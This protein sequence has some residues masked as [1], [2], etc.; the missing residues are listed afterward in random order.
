MGRGG[1][2]VGAGRKP[3]GI[4]RKVSLTLTEDEWAKIENSGGT[5]ATFLR[6][7]MLH[8]QGEE[9]MAAF[10]KEEA[11]RNRKDALEKSNEVARLKYELD[12]SNLNQNAERL[13]RRDVEELWQIHMGKGDQYTPA[14]LEEAYDALIRNLFP[15]GGDLT[16]IKTIPQ[17]IC[18]FSGKR[19][20]SPSSLIRAA[21]PRLIAFAE[22]RLKDRAAAEER[23]R[24]KEENSR[25]N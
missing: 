16:E 3:Q 10:S 5:V 7:L 23:R 9:D 18:P 22:I 8:S 25:R 13:T 1:K 12:N 2:R 4:T 21:I 20:G 14:S 19:F 17:Y 24:E 6:E 11:E 15:S